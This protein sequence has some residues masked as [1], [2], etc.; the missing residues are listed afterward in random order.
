VI[1][2]RGG[3]T[4][5]TEVDESLALGIGAL[6][7]VDAES[8][9]D[10]AVVGVTGVGVSAPQ[11]KSANGAHARTIGIRR[12]RDERDLRMTPC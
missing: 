9:D 1:A 8:L 12:T 2:G 6:A 4:A 10:V 7:I 3:A 5:A 11:A